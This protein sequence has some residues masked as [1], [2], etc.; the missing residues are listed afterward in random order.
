MYAIKGSTMTAIG[1]AI[2]NKTGI[3]SFEDE[4]VINADNQ[5]Y[6]VIAP[7]GGYSYRCIVE[8]TEKVHDIGPNL[9]IFENNKGGKGLYSIEA[10]G[11]GDDITITLVSSS[12][13]ILFYSSISHG[14]KDS[15]KINI[16]VIPLD[17]N[18]NE[19]K[20]TPLEMAEAIDGL[21]T[22][23]ESALNITGS[24]MYKFSSDSWNW[25]IEDYGDKITTSEIS[26]ASYMF[27]C[28]TTLTKIPFDI[29]LS[30][31]ATTLEKMFERCYELETLP[32]VFWNEMPTSTVKISNVMNSCYKLKTIPEW[33]IELCEHNFN[34][35]Q[36]KGSW[37]DFSP[38]QSVFSYCKSIR[39]IPERL[40]SV[41]WNPVATG[42]YYTV[43]YSRPFADMTAVDELLNI[44]L[45]D[46][47]YT[48]NQFSG[49]FSTLQHISRITI[50]TN[51]DGTP[52]V[53]QWKNQTWDLTSNLGC[54]QPNTWDF[55]SDKRVQDE[56]TYQAL[57]NDPDW[58]TFHLE[59]CRY[60][61][62]SA[63]ET[64]NSLPDTSAY[65]TNTIKF[66]GAAGAL[67]DGGAINTLTEEEI[68]VATA[69]GWTVTL[70]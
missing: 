15:V 46:R 36:S 53:R 55:T 52:L 29:N 42:D 31:S 70:V 28:S 43:I 26:N 37:T 49:W 47:A 50:A 18:G 11:R 14:R 7:E 65:G 24:C 41:L 66:K 21:M 34:T 8:M 25:F 27:N 45:E 23:P 32:N 19:F 39:K 67:T 35:A 1:D 33:L 38:F 22:L 30:K 9:N 58:W 48:S 40:M 13:K 2:R 12:N 5:T 6:T 54:G 10:L 3:Y 64:I 61:H 44:R 63:V 51:E 69:K 60:N 57:K 20:Y 59:Y 17:E 16:T 4:F 56:A 68:A 62:D